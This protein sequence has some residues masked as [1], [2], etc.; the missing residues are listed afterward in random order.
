MTWPTT[1]PPMETEA[2]ISSFNLGLNVS[3]N[4][5]TDDQMT[6]YMTYKIGEILV[7]FFKILLLDNTGH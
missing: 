1:V 4:G 7:K 6:S 5:L 2:T 3:D